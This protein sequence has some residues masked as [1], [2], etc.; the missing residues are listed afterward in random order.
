MLI[1]VVFLSLFTIALV[2]AVNP[3][4]KPNP[5]HAS[6]E[7]MVNVGG[8]DKTLQAAIDDGSLS[9]GL[10]KVYDS[11]WQPISASPSPYSFLTYTTGKGDFPSYNQDEPGLVVVKFSENPSDASKPIAMQ[12]SPSVVYPG[13]V[14]GTDA[15]YNQ[16]DKQIY[17][18]LSTRMGPYMLYSGTTS[19]KLRVIAYK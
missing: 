17:F 6:N 9:R 11:G 4:T 12:M 15:Y 2:I 5:G 13:Y 19:G 18:P 3:S 10:T 1:L 16:T 14:Q 8:A 7:V